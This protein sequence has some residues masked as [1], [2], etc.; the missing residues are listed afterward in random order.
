MMAMRLPDTGRPD[1]R[2]VERVN[3]FLSKGDDL[4]S[5]LEMLDTHRNR[6][7]MDYA[8]ELCPDGTNTQQRRWR[9]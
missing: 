6:M 9:T 1:R 3:R 7:L 4:S 2:R 5:A 8:V